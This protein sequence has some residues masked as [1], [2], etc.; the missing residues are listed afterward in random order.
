MMTLINV[1]Y[2]FPLIERNI[3]LTD[4]EDEKISAVDEIKNA[5]DSNYCDN[6]ERVAELT[7]KTLDDIINCFQ[8]SMRDVYTKF[9]TPSVANF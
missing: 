2:L 3:Q 9:R 5:L 7:L 4:I 6:P 1:H 8:D